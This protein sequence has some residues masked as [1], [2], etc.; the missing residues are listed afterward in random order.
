[1]HLSIVIVS[2]LENP[3]ALSL[4]RGKPLA[5]VPRGAGIPDVGQHT[6][7]C[8]FEKHRFAPNVSSNTFEVAE[9]W[10]ASTASDTVRH[11]AFDTE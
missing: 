10:E 3:Y 8:L 7:Q 11:R 4:L 5:G 6:R 2:S 9:D 1:M